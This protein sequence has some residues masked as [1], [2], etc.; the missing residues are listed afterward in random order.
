MFALIYMLWAARTAQIALAPFTVAS[1]GF[2]VVNFTVTGTP[3]D[4]VT[5]TAPRLTATSMG[6]WMAVGGRV[7]AGWLCC[8]WLSLLSAVFTSG[9][10][11]LLGCAASLTTSLCLQYRFTFAKYGKGKVYLFKAKAKNA[12]GW[13]PEC[14]AVPFTTPLSGV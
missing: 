10:N 13:G 2:A 4:G 5:A 3:R 1:A 6:S 14:A 9:A 7:S 11:E 12:A 8:T